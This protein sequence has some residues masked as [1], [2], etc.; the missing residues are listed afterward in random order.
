MSSMGH[1]QGEGRATNTLL[2]AK[3]TA[4]LGGEP[5][6]KTKQRCNGHEALNPY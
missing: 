3:Y 4:P 6:L 1:P 5:V 2:T